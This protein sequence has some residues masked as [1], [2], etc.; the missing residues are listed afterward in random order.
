MV[1]SV[2]RRTFILASLGAMTQTEWFKTVREVDA[3]QE[4][5][6][7][8]T[9]LQESRQ[10]QFSKKTEDG[11][12]LISQPERAV[13]FLISG[14][15]ALL[16]P[17]VGYNIN[18]FGE[19]SSVECILKSMRDQML[20]TTHG[21]KIL[22]ERPQLTAETLNPAWLESLSPTTLGHQYWKFTGANDKRSP[23]KFIADEELS[24]V[25]LRYRQIHDIVHILTK[26][27]VDLA[28]EL[29]VKAFEFGNMGLPMTGMA[30]FA[31]FKLSEKRKKNVDMLSSYLN[32]LSST[33][34]YIL[35]WE[36]MMERDVEELKAELD[37]H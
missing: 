13:L 12:V 2:Q 18:N 15:S 33:P 11:R 34:L 30:C 3:F 26:S 24:Y 7:Q 8:V 25:Y 14:L 27:Q 4:P 5:T 23:V 9:T 6:P 29:P 37:I 20:Q 19:A 35:P 36:E 22:R 32:G 31:Y 16:H 10:I 21:R 28:G 17:E 1:F